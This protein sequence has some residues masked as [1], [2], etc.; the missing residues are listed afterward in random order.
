MFSL[1]RFDHVTTFWADRQ[2]VYDAKYMFRTD[3]R[4]GLLWTVMY[5]QMHL[6]GSTINVLTF[7]HIIYLPDLREVRDELEGWVRMHNCRWNSRS[8]HL[9]I[10]ATSAWPSLVRHLY[11]PSLVSWLGLLETT[12]G[13]LET[14]SCFITAQTVPNPI[15]V[16]NA[17]L[18]LMG[19][20][21][22]LFYFEII[23]IRFRLSWN[24][25]WALMFVRLSS[26]SHVPFFN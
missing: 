1:L 14:L 18:S 24:S 4:L 2:S 26:L 21:T 7:L 25:L 9:W 12:Y 22:I 16:K 8:S 15:P 20:L 17:R 19:Q 13:Y 6:R 5:R 11:L 10:L 3:S 23:F